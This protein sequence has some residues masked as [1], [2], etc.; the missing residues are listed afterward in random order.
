MLIFFPLL[1][2][3]FLSES[4]GR[5]LRPIPQLRGIPVAS[6]LEI[7]GLKSELI[8]CTAQM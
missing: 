8:T 6:N 1:P 7:S 3:S 5:T 2:L 4:G